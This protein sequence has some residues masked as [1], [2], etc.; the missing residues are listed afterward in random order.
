MTE[1]RLGLTPAD[2]RQ[3]FSPMNVSLEE[4]P[5]MLAGP[6]VYRYHAQQLHELFVVIKNTQGTLSP[7]RNLKRI[8]DYEHSSFVGDAQ[9]PMRS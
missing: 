3:S 1:N 8:G 9:G 2:F 7:G 5:T 6:L 4:L